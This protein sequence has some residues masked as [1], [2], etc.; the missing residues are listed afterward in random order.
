MKK[1]LKIRSKSYSKKLF[2]RTAGNKGKGPAG[3]P[4]QRGG[5]RM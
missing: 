2:K 3:R 4:H 1:R 5:W